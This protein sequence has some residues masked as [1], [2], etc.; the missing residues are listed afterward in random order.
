[1]KNF[2]LKSL[3]SASSLLNIA[4]IAVAVAAFYII[5]VSTSFDI[6]FN[7]DIKNAKNIYQICITDLDFQETPSNMI[8]RPLG[9]EIISGMPFIE[10][11]GCF[12]RD[13]IGDIFAL[14]NGVWENLHL[15]TAACTPQ[16]L[17]VFGFEF[18]EGQ[19]AGFNATG[20]VVI[21]QSAAE[22]FGLN[23]G[24]IL[25]TSPRDSAVYEVAAVFKDFSKNT[26]F[27]EYDVLKF[28]SN[29][30]IDN[31]SSWSYN[32]Y[33][34][35]KDGTEDVNKKFVENFQPII[36]KIVAKDDEKM[37]EE[38]I[39]E[40]VA[41]F[42]PEAVRLTDLQFHN[43]EGFG[44]RADKKIVYSMLLI[45]IL[46]MLIAYVNYINF[47]FSQIPQ[48]LKSVNIRK[49]HGCSR[50]NLIFS[51]IFEALTFSFLAV[52]TAVLIVRSIQSV[53]LGEVIG[54]TLDFSKNL[55]V[56]FLTIG[57]AFTAAFLA[58]VYPAFYVTKLQ[59]ALAL[60]GITAQKGRNIITKYVLTGFQF[61]AAIILII[62]TLFIQR[63]NSYL[64][65]K[66][67]G[68][69]KE[70]LLIT[71]TTDKICTKPDFIR[72]KLLQNTDIQDITW[73]GYFLGG[74]E[75]MVYNEKLNGEDIKYQCCLV[76]WN[77]M[78]FMG[79]KVVDGRNFQEAD[80]KTSEQLL[81]FNEEA[82]KKYNLNFDS[83]I[84]D[85][86][87]IIGFCNELIFK[88]LQYHSG[89]FAFQVYNQSYPYPL[90]C[91]YV[92][93]KEG[94]EN[95][96]TMEF[97]RQTLLDAD[98]EYDNPMFE[99]STYNHRI[100]EAYTGETDFAALIS[101]F[102]FAA[103]LITVMGLTGVVLFETERRRKEIGIRK[104]SGATTKDILLLFN[105]R[106]AVLVGVC[107][108]IALPIAFLA[109]QKYLSAFANHCPLNWYI[110]A[111]AFVL[112]LLLSL[113]VVTFSS[114][115]AANENPVKTLKTE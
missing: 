67:L 3:F 46:I 101:A 36:R 94:A 98:P 37:T 23:I 40:E 26:E 10:N 99:I 108:V 49:I 89:E 42:T 41:V 19:T 17:E 90:H 66:D 104:I 18:S 59:P 34:Q 80:S 35:V 68:F 11:C 4:G 109:V 38:E 62:C 63:N 22:K 83:K 43:S 27:A 58:S 96:K 29:N 112:T 55:T 20:K 65:N 12:R 100:S 97:V 91:L 6:N 44:H 31:T 53:H 13:Y 75:S 57:L 39:D 45:A 93:T 50:K 81:I 87:S 92:R 84:E 60:K 85:K 70:N 51:F 14:K 74:Q 106:F 77:F 95:A 2:R 16:L 24:S 71:Y 61:T 64:L 111:A 114:L 1:M 78:D 76:A 32:Y 113:A 30:D 105:K 8:N 48:K 82:R 115:K 79:I 69:N 28:L 47:F 102:T 5:L 72:E 73:A 33:F 15:K 52:L 86:K 21:S 56:S 110:F 107:F 88:P 7:K 25:K 54:H 103:V 9:E